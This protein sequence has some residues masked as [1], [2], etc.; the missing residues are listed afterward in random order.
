MF[1]FLGSC[2]SSSLEK[3]ENKKLFSSY[4]L[5]LSQWV[6]LGAIA[7]IGL[8][9]TSDV[10]FSNIYYYLDA[11]SLRVIESERHISV[12][13][14]QYLGS[15][16]SISNN[17]FGGL[18]FNESRFIWFDT[19]TFVSYNLFFR[20]HN[21]FLIIACEGGIPALLLFSFLILH[22]Y[23][24]IYEKLPAIYIETR[25]VRLEYWS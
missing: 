16:L 18:G 23:I 2:F 19:N 9:I 21:L 8:T 15:L 11:V 12:R 14:D 1:I 5:F 10:S 17:P 25:Y 7:V 24:Q 20:P 3:Q 6:F 22:P 13:L 4:I